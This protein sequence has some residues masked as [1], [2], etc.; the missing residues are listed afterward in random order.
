MSRSRTEMAGEIA[1]LLHRIF[2]R[3]IKPAGRPPLARDVTLEQM[4][5][6][7]SIHRL[8]GPSMSELSEALGLQPGS[9][10]PLVDALVRHGLVERF[11]DPEDRR[12]VRVQATAEGKRDRERMHRA[13]RE[14]IAHLLGDLEVQEVRRIRDALELF[15]VAAS[16][17]VSADAGRGPESE[18]NER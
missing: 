4:R 7:H 17:R 1:E 15:H 12:V 16:R 3:H 9:V 11:D 2:S 6:L 14:R 13:V 8:E 18:R 5:C 10:T